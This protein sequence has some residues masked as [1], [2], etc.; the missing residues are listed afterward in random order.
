MGFDDPNTFTLPPPFPPRPRGRRRP[1]PDREIVRR[2]APYCRRLG[3][4]RLEIF[5]S[6]AR[7]EAQV[8]SDVDL[9]ATFRGIPGL[10]FFSMAEEMS[11]RLG[12]PVDLLLAED[13]AEMINPFRKVTIERDRRV[14]YT[15]RSDHKGA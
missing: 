15:A 14:I 11:R 4:V 6:V 8:G 1:P 7:G 13:V 5:G 9:I 10:S 2:L 12:V 3:I